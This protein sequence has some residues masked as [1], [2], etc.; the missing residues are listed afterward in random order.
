MN[1]SYLI[2]FSNQ[3]INKNSFKTNYGACNLNGHLTLLTEI[4]ESGDESRS[5]TEKR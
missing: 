5:T 4:G 2:I 3:V 1:L